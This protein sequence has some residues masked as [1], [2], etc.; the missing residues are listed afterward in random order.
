MWMKEGKSASD[1]L[2]G[3]QKEGFSYKDLIVIYMKKLRSSDCLKTSALFMQHEYKVA[4]RV[5]IA[6]SARVHSKFRLS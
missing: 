2:D 3:G 5:Q 6:N 4:T 1:D